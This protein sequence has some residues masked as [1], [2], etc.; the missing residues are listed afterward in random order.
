[1]EEMAAG[2][3]RT[4]DAAFRAQFAELVAWR[5]DVRRFRAGAVPEATLEALF[6]LAALAPLVGNCQLTRFVRVTGSSV[7]HR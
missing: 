3:A 6:E 1:M 5:R 7:F 4:F 2:N